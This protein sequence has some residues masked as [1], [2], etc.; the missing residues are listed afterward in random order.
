MRGGERA[1]VATCLYGTLDLLIRT[2]MP[3]R[4]CL[5]CVELRS[6]RPG[7]GLGDGGR[8]CN[9]HAYVHVISVSGGGGV[10]LWG[11]GRA[12]IKRIRLHEFASVLLARDN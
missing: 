2:Y 9:E 10:L 12:R 8:H 7:R 4:G 1:T 3:C 5:M 11:A 6:H